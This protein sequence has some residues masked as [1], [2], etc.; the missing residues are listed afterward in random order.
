MPIST[1][2]S[3]DRL[4]YIFRKRS[5]LC[6]TA[7]KDLL[8]TDHDVLDVSKEV[9]TL[10]KHGDDEIS[11]A[12]NRLP[13]Q[14]MPMAAPGQ[15]AETQTDSS[16][17]TY[18]DVST[19]TDW[20]E[21]RHV[22]GQIYCWALTRM[23]LETSSCQIIGPR[24]VDF[25]DGLPQ[26]SEISPKMNGHENKSGGKPKKL[27]QEI[28]LAGDPESAST[29]DGRTADPELQD[30]HDEEPTKPGDA[31]SH[32]SQAG[33]TELDSIPKIRWES[34]ETLSVKVPWKG[35]CIRVALPP[36]PGIF[37]SPPSTRRIPVVYR[38]T[39]S[40]ETPSPGPHGLADSEIWSIK[41]KPTL[42][43][44]A[45]G[46]EKAKPEWATPSSLTFWGVPITSTP[47]ASEAS[48]KANLEV[49]VFFQPA[50]TGRLA[51]IFVFKGV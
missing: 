4:R 49:P 12:R 48:G 25:G 32:N 30:H 27:S 17:L 29:S 22:K 26:G 51:D 36:P 42:T 18:C 16:T 10:L 38:E 41:Q 50:P 31:E 40:T 44:R 37:R 21:E 47:S 23:G 33:D 34:I 14:V 11:T 2:G 6:Q 13:P 5:D 15:E 19:Q 7:L 39:I 45:V 1:V 8:E 46:F 43:E 3:L 20:G 28:R 24:D 35:K 9:E